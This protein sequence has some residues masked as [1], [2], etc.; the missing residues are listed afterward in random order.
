MLHGLVTGSIPPDPVTDDA[1][2]EGEVPRQWRSSAPESLVLTP[3]GRIVTDLRLLRLSGGEDGSFLLELPAAGREP[4]LAHFTR[5]L[6]PRLARPFDLTASTRMVT[7]AGPEAVAL[8]ASAGFDAARVAS[9][10]PGEAFIRLSAPGVQLAEALAGRGEGEVLVL[11]R[12]TSVAS[13]AFDLLGTP[14][15]VDAFEARLAAEGVEAGDDAAWQTLRIEHGTPETGRELGEDVLPHEAGL[16][17]RA[18]DHQKGC[19]TGQEVVVRIRD[20]GRVNRH[21]RGLLLGSGPEPPPGTPL[22]SG[23]GG[24]EV[25]ELRSVARSERFGQLIGLGYVRR[26]IEPGDRIRV[27]GG[28]GPEARVRALTPD[29][30][31][32]DP[33]ATMETGGTEGYS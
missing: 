11:V 29:G 6:P 32:A 28:D 19:Y 16:E 8:A 21:L 4:L 31:A 18:I 30:W 15:A 14:G 2:E 3:K 7:V 33:G 24:K 27:G 23:D 9:L 10:A 25:G 12:S 22:V 20:R 17:R 26:E 5:Y 1:G 13:P